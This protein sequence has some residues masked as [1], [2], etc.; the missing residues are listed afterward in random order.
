[1]VS[2]FLLSLINSVGSDF[3]AD[4]NALTVFNP[5][6]IKAITNL[7]CPNLNL[8]FNIIEND[9]IIKVKYLTK[10][11]NGKV[12]MKYSDFNMNSD[13]KYFYFNQIGNICY[14]DSL[15]REI[16]LFDLSKQYDLSNNKPIIHPKIDTT[17]IECNL[18]PNIL[19]ATVIIENKTNEKIN[20]SNY[21]ELLKKVNLK[22][23]ITKEEHDIKDIPRK[24]NKEGKGCDST[25]YSID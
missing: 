16:L 11:E 21:S 6:K 22:F 25:R 14:L 18:I 24:Y 8:F 5:I 19:K 12:T 10:L 1:M 7:T 15:Y 4:C 23:K 2:K 20:L 13:Y 9:N 17:N 3:S